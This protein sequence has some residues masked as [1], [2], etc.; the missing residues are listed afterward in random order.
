[1][2]NEQAAWE[3]S[4]ELWIQQHPKL[5]RKQQKQG[6]DIVRIKLGRSDPLS[7]FSLQ[8]RLNDSFQPRFDTEVF[9]QVV[10][11]YVIDGTSLVT[12]VISRRL[13]VARDVGEF[14]EAIDDQVVPV[15]LG[16]E[17]V[18]R[19]IHH[20]GDVEQVDRSAYDAQKDLDQTIFQISASYR[21]LSLENG[22]K[23]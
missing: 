6:Y 21:L 7:T 17:A 1:M 13:G 14:L 4:Q 12:R 9:V 19:S 18:Y 5:R 3:E 10:L 11:R 22:T 16:K 20:G 23:R 8:M 15:L 2:V